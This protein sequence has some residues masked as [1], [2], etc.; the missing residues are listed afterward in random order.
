MAEPLP[1]F[2][3][4]FQWDKYTMTNYEGDELKIC[5]NRTVLKTDNP[6]QMAN[7]LVNSLPFYVLQLCLSIFVINLFTLILKPLRQPRLVPY[8]LSGCVMGASVWNVGPLRG[9]S[10]KLIPFESNL[11][12]ETMSNLGVM[13][14]MFLVGLE[15][16]LK[17]LRHVG[18]K[19]LSIS[20]TGIVIPMIAGWFIYVGIKPEDQSNKQNF[21]GN[22]FWG[23]CMTAT[24]FPDLARILSDMKLMQ[25]D[26]GR[27]ALTSAIVNDVVSWGLL[28]AAITYDHGN[29]L[30][31]AP[32]FFLVPLFWFIFRPI[33]VYLIKH[34]ACT[35]G[36]E[37]AQGMY[38]SKH[39]H[40]VMAAVPFFGLMTDALGT[41][42]I[43]GAFLFGLII[44]N[45]ELGMKLMEVLEEYVIGVMLPPFFLTTGL[46][47]NTD[48]F[49]RN[50]NVLV[51][52]GV[53]VLTCITKISSTAVGS[54]FFGF[55]AWD[56]VA[57]GFLMNTKGVL[58]LIILNSGRNLKG[59]DQ[60]SFGVMLVSIFIMTFMVVPFISLAY[61]PTQ[62]FKRIIRRTLE[63]GKPDDELR[64]IACVHANRHTS[65]MVNLLQLVN[66]SKKVPLSVFAMHL[67]ELTGRNAAMLIIQDA[68]KSV[69]NNSN[70]QGDDENLIMTAFENFEARN[71][72]SVQVQKIAV[73][74][75]YA[76]MHEDVLNF[77]G[78]KG[79][80]LIIVPFHKQPVTDGRLEEENPSIREVNNNLLASSW[81]SVG[82][83]VDR[84]LSS[85][86]PT[87]SS[88]NL[89][90]QSLRIA[91]LYIGGPD[92]RE[93]LACAWRMSSGPNVSLTVVR[94]MPGKDA[95]DITPDQNST[96]KKGPGIL[97]ILAKM[98]KER[99]LDDA[100]INEFR[101][102]SMYNES[103][104]YVNKIVDS[105]DEIFEVINKS[106]IDFDFYIVGRGRD[107]P[108]SLTSGLTEWCE[109][110][111]LGPIGD[112]LVQSELMSMASVLVV[113]QKAGAS[114]DQPESDSPKGTP[115]A[116]DK[117]KLHGYNEVP[118]YE[119]FV[120]HRKGDD[121]DDFVD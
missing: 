67:V 28:I 119:P 18:A 105:G 49:F 42:S 80:N 93:A 10:Q 41:H 88:V 40:F 81:C 13:Y 57:L 112:M 7:P 78:D 106:F 30:M 71:S 116:G 54:L 111:E 12:L 53:I 51:V 32:T 44:P 70:H 100:Y 66:P 29:L 33:I 84:G 6:W 86:Y 89:G 38:N 90:D 102:R 24:S 91:M 110:P 5:Y 82:I 117:P 48:L 121:E 34:S 118:R 21:S 94:F 1:K 109:Y 103:I 14:Y 87:A 99:Q 31:L 65:G 19:V 104:S 16:D 43:F 64:F 85:I 37:A 36:S 68:L 120:N 92:D 107:T 74:S 50:T 23:V 27:T 62:R 69:P 77:A 17:P 9:F 79:V 20:F 47:T 75:A 56:G 108:L 35:T 97:T 8:I 52:I 114:S 73:V 2:G 39:L 83:F 4:P 58:A 22:F 95:L 15:M 26:L 96:D 55:N 98:E 45:G 76:N 72:E 11:V 25:T 3:E 60:Q 59:F 63:K 46:R 61:K 113:Q 101:F 115:Q